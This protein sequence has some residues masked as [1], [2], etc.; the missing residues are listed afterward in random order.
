MLA[1]LTSD[2]SSQLPV[3]RGAAL[4][5]LWTLGAAGDERLQDELGFFT[6]PDELGDFLTG[7]FALAREAVQRRRRLVARIDELVLGF[8]DQEFLHAL[9]ALRLAFSRFTPREK[10]QLIRTLLED[11]GSAPDEAAATASKIERLEVPASAVARMVAL[12]DE[13]RRR[14]DRYGI[15]R[16]GG[17]KS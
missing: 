4:G 14:L 10:H 17:P 2:D 5:A 1:R 8:D 15:R 6:H 16:P 7:L 11:T 13:L 3:I 9:P 12:E